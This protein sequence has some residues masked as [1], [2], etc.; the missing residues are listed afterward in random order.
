MEVKAID[1]Q[2][3][4]AN[5]SAFKGI[6]QWI[7]ND[8][9]AYERGC[10][11]QILVNLVALVLSVVALLFIGIPFYYAAQEWDRLATSAQNESYTLKKYQVGE[12]V[13]LKEN[14][15]LLR[16]AEAYKQD[17]LAINNTKEYYEELERVYTKHIRLLN[18]EKTTT[19]DFN[20][21]S[22]RGKSRLKVNKTLRQAPSLE[23]IKEKT[24]KF[25]GS[26]DTL[27]PE[28]PDQK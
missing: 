27:S 6:I 25:V 24:L 20:L 1:L 7:R 26:R 12:K 11:C 15:K 19:S 14:A 18:S 4:P 8:H 17:Q 13:L 10:T 28:F 5:D 9:N 23:E 2:Q 3:A 21:V 22:P 16:E